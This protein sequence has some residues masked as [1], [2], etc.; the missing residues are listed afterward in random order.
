MTETPKNNNGNEPVTQIPGQI[1]SKEKERFMVREFPAIFLLLGIVCMFAYMIYDGSH[2]ST[3]AMIGGWTGIW[4][5][6]FLK[7]QATRLMSIILMIDLVFAIAGF[8]VMEQFPAGSTPMQLK[9]LYTFLGQ[10]IAVI[11]VLFAKSAHEKEKK[12]R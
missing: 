12:D 4:S 7:K 10:L 2:G 11:C 9:W 8:I 6:A 3:Y 1:D 5:A